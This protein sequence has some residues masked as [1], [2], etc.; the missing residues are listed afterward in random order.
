[1]RR[2]I[3]NFISVIHSFFRFLL[4]KLIH[5]KRIKVATIERFSP[6]VV[7]E[8]A[9]GSCVSIGKCVRAHSGCKFKV[10]KNAVLNIGDGVKINYNCIFVC[11]ERIDIGSGTEFGPSVYIYDHDHDYSVGLKAG[12]FKSSPISLGKNCW[13]GAN[14]VILRGSSIGDNCV[15]GAGSIVSK[16]IPDN[17]VFV[18]KRMNV[19]QK[20]EEN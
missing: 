11:R 3:N 8:A 18:Q 12:K 2:S 10:R 9:K 13:I 7:F 20:I 15:I 19:I 16:D 6:N 14:T 17:S 4:L 1:M 5:G